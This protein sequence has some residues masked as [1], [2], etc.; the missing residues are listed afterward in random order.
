MTTLSDML[1][2]AR[3]AVLRRG[4]PYD[5]ADDLVQEAFLRLEGYERAHAVQSKEAFLVSTAVNLTIDRARRQRRSP[6]DDTSRNLDTVPEDKAGPDEILSARARL[7]RLEDGMAQLPERT[8][9]ILLSRRIDGTG[10]REIADA[11][12]MSVSAVEKQVARATLTL[13]KWMQE[14]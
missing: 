10:Y 7:R 11:E 8:R 1:R 4:V 3:A 13:M 14:W 12:G 5:D 9:R 2:K 6:F